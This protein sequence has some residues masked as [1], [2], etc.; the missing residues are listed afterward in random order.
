MRGK[1]AKR[2]KKFVDILIENTPQDQLDK[3]KEQLLNEVKEFWYKD[4]N[5]R[6]FID[7]VVGGDI[8]EACQEVQK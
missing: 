2:L 7:K 6:K 3:S 8:E 4:P 1:T 5:S